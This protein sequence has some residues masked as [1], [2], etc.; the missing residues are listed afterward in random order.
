MTEHNLPVTYRRYSLPEVF[1][2][3]HSWMRWGAAGLTAFTL[4]TILS[5]RPVRN[6]MFEFFLISHIL[7]VA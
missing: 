2:F 4:A 6:L 5:V 7:L 3:S 1:D